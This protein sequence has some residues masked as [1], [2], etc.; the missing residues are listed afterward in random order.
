MMSNALCGDFVR[1]YS[2]EFLKT[3]DFQSISKNCWFTARD[4]HTWNLTQIISNGQNLRHDKWKDPS[5]FRKA[6]L[7]AKD[8][9]FH[10]YT[11]KSPT[12][13]MSHRTKLF[14]FYLSVKLCACVLQKTRQK[15]FLSSFSRSLFIWKTY[16]KVS[17]VVPK[18][19]FGVVIILIMTSTQIF[20][21]LVDYLYF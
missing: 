14:Y 12:S 6:L 7:I 2:L 8:F 18:N 19:Y 16:P 21:L 10:L 9:F 11:A 15:N 3:K 13:R 17:W 5:Y 4:L 1:L 20:N